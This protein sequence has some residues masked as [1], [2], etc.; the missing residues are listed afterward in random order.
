MLTRIWDP[1]R[2]SLVV[3]GLNPSAADETKDDPTVRRCQGYARL[4]GFGGLV[5]LNLFAYRAT[6]PADLKATGDPVG[7][8]NDAALRRETAGRRVLAAWGVH[9]AYRDRAPAVLRLLAGRDVVCLARTK[10]GFPRHPLY[11]RA[12]WLPTPYPGT[13]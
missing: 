9:G 4:W 1:T 5:M 11:C 12:D 13:P 6:N 7:P 10:A 8:I 2:P 3:I